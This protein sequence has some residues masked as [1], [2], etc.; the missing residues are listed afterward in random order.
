MALAGTCV[1][2]KV[3]RKTMAIISTVLLT[4][5]LFIFGALDKLY[6][7]STNN[8][9]IYA[10]VAFIFLFQGSYSVAWTPL[11]VLYPPGRCWTMAQKRH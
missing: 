3:G 11:A 2:D 4:I 9:G 5:C 7:T 8:S 1:M 10:S 6:G